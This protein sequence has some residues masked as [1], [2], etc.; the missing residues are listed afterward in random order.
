[1]PQHIFITGEAGSGKTRML[2]DRAAE[3]GGAAIKAPHQRALAIAVM[4]GA[5]RRLQSTLDKFCP[6]LPVT[7]STIHSFALGVVNRWRRSL[8]IT[9]PVTI[10]ETSCGLA[11]E[12]FRARATFDEVMQLACRA[13][14][15]DTVQ[16]ALG[17]TY[18]IVIV[19]E[20]QDCAEDT[21]RFVLSLGIRST[22]LLA[23]DR[24]QR[25]A[26]DEEKC[27]AVDWADSQ[28]LVGGV[29]YEDLTGCRRT[30]N[31]GILRAARTLRD[32]VAAT[33]ATVPVYFAPTYGPAAFRIV[34]RFLPRPGN[35]TL[36]GTC[37]IIALSLADPLLA[38]LIKSFQD[39]LA[40]R[41]PNFKVQWILPLR[42]EEQSQQLLTELGIDR[43]AKP[44]TPWNPE[45]TAGT[46]QAIRVARG[47]VEFA[48]LR[49]IATIPQALT[50][51]FARSAVHNS[52]V[53]SR[54]SPRFQVLTAHG[55]K[56]REFH[57]VFVFW[58]FK[59]E[60]WSPTLQ[61]RL[62]YNAI[63][64]AKL[65]CT[66]LVLGDQKR[67]QTDPVINLLGPAMPAIDPAWKKGKK[68][69]PKG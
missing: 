23:A 45:R 52:R 8:D 57:H 63:T 21:L 61:R 12:N 26:E 34:E 10:C 59:G 49:G 14:Q 36:S 32:N 51:D 30:S 64:R 20:F 25:L 13:L 28:K 55:A 9:L 15:S 5:R 62:L 4:H 43:T 16:R 68:A 29:L 46:S 56:N 41:N 18:P 42:E 6:N 69:R 3:I 22:L 53:F 19:D 11:E 27:P 66:V 65:D 35:K 39:Q 50:I 31:D 37:A 58:G 67:V 47:I 1:M 54:S 24:F 38:K 7:V 60:M 44:D 33:T 40:K 48:K 17:E 2:M